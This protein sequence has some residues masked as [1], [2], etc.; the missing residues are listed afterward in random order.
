MGLQI[1]PVG[2][3]E[4]VRVTHGSNF[5]GKATARRKYETKELEAAIETGGRSVNE[6]MEWQRVSE[7]LFT[8]VMTEITRILILR[9]NH[10]TRTRILPEKNG[11]QDRVPVGR[12][13]PD[14]AVAFAIRLR[15]IIFVYLWLEFR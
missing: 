13:F 12:C 15:E 3:V 2:V 4:Q 5:G 11:H 6:D 9:A 14:L 7:C 8:R 10:G 1:S